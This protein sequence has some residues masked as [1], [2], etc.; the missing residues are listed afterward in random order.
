[1][2]FKQKNKLLYVF[3]ILYVISFFLPA[4]DGP[5]DTLYGAHCAVWVVVG[6]IVD[7]DNTNFQI[8]LFDIFL[9][10]PNFLMITTFLFRKRLPV[11]VKYLFSIIVFTSAGYWAT[12]FKG[13][14]PE[15]SYLSIGYWLWFI[16]STA[17][18][19]TATLL[20]NKTNI[21]TVL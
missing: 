19:T 9:M 18:M 14:L 21:K 1:M 7:L 15:S 4:L 5:Q 20:P 16:S 17:Y 8:I 6:F 12:E 10:L 11:F 3:V 13:T 2:T